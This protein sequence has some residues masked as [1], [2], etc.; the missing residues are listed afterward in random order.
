MSAVDVD[1][2]EKDTL[3]EVIDDNSRPLALSQR[4]LCSPLNN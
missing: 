2:P 1:D 4:K 3:G